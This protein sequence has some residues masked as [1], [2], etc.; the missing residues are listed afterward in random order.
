MKGRI[1]ER[2]LL[3]ALFGVLPLIFIFLVALPSRKRMDAK[4]VRMEAISARF[5]TLPAIQP[6]TALERKDKRGMRSSNR[7]C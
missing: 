6:L 4:K 3:L 5:K 2:L 1:G 7:S